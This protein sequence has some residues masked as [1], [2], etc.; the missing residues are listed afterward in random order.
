LNNKLLGLL[1][2]IVALFL[3][4]A[5]AYGASG[6][7]DAPLRFLAALL[8]AV[9]MGV[10]YYLTREHEAWLLSMRHVINGFAGAMLYAVFAWM[11]S[12]AI[13]AVPAVGDLGLRPAIVFPVIFGCLFGP[14]TGFIAG[15][16]GSFF[17]NLLGGLP[18]LPEWDMAAGLVGFVA[19]MHL[20]FRERQR[21]LDIAVYII[22]GLSIF[23]A[24]GYLLNSDIQNQFASA[25]IT[26]WLGYS[27]IAGAI[28]AL[29]LRYAFPEEEWTQVVV[30][31][32]LANV[33]ALGLMALAHLWI[34]AGRLTAVEATLGHFLPAAG[35]SL[36]AVVVLV[37]FL[38][39][40]YH[41]MR[42][43]PA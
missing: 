13:F 29:A 5:L 3:L 34:D 20:L 11:F 10:V 9:G 24:V 14:M 8:G 21:A 33:V 19:G 42:E 23:S 4:L 38:I 35:P 22:G 43:Q 1:L 6:A 36:V 2:P 17:G 12:G 16:F 27:V 18:I 40:T 7:A 31:G 39:A 26:P 37:P 30:W 32:A 28:L 15:G 25:P 41:V